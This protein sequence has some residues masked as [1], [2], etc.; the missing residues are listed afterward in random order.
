M[1]LVCLVEGRYLRWPV[2]S[3]PG[4]Y[5]GFGCRNL[6]TLPLREVNVWLSVFSMLMRDGKGCPRVRMRHFIYLLSFFGLVS[7]ILMSPALLVWSLLKV[8]SGSCYTAEKG[9][10]FNVCYRGRNL[11]NPRAFTQALTYYSGLQSYVR[12]PLYGPRCLHAELCRA[13]V[14]ASAE[15][16]A[17]PLNS[18]PSAVP[19]LFSSCLSNVAVPILFHFPFLYVSI[20]WI[21]LYNFSG[22]WEADCIHFHLTFCV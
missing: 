18:L 13:D 11:N 16:P 19:C 5:S 14:L 4:W 21:F 7:A 10:C 9:T 8:S 3:L 20:S 15:P 12:L 6:P 2:R 1:G 17:A 22:M